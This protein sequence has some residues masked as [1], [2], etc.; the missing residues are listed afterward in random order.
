MEGALVILLELCNVSTL[1][2][3]YGHTVIRFMNRDWHSK[4]EEQNG[5]QPDFLDT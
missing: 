1:P 3:I 2:I 5:F 4:R